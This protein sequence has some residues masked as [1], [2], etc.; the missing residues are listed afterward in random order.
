LSVFA[1]M[2]VG[3]AGGVTCWAIAKE[4]NPPA[5]SGTA[6]S[7]VNGGG[8]LGV[9]LLQPA[10]GWILDRAAGQPP[11][12]AYRGAAALLGAVA[13]TGVLAAF[14]LRETHGRNVSL[15]SPGR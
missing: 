2:G 11:A 7:L 8:F 10:V 1:L 9:A 4:N 3:I 13:L 14:G 12:D 6:T 15:G 5:L